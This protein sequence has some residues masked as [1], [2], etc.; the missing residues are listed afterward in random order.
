MSVSPYR[1]QLPYGG[2]ALSFVVLLGG[3]FVAAGCSETGETGGDSKESSASGAYHTD[4]EVGMLDNDE[5][6][7]PR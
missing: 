5:F 7:V 4:Q 1:S 6:C 2:W 3:F